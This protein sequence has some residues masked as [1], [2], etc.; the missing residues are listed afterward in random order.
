MPKTRTSIPANLSAESLFLS[1]RTCCVCREPGKRVQIHHVDE[2]PSNNI[3][4]NFAVL[5]F[6]CHDQTQIRG[7][8]GKHLTEVV[9]RKYRDEWLQRVVLRR[10]EADRFAVS[11]MAG[12]TVIGTAQGPNSQPNGNLFT[13]LDAVPEIRKALLAIARPDW[14]SGVTARMNQATY[15]YIDGLQGVLVKLASYYPLES[16]EEEDPHYFFSDIIASRF[17]WHRAHA[18]PSGPGTGGKIVGTICGGSVKVDVENMVV[19][20]VMS[21]IGYSEACGWKRWER[22]W[23]SAAPE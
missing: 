2:N 15:N 7:G 19:D 13:Y 9:V 21:L 17:R 6:E 11:K 8:F 23:K 4:E 22:Q 5:C 14:D 10:D 18:E 16:F 12:G 20:M 1:D 3:A